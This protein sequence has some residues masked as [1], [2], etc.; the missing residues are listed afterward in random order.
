MEI[1]RVKMDRYKMRS[2]TKECTVPRVTP[3]HSLGVSEAAETANRDQIMHRVHIENGVIALSGHNEVFESAS[4]FLVTRSSCCAH[5]VRNHV[6][7]RRNPSLPKLDQLW[8]APTH[9]NDMVV[10]HVIEPFPSGHP[11]GVMP[12]G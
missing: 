11:N 6:A 5:T 2:T 7:S 3:A 4:L 8:P 10:T 1:I 9:R 12:R